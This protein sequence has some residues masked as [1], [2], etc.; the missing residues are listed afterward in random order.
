MPVI[1]WV[2]TNQ[3]KNEEQQG[4]KK[5]THHH[6]EC[7]PFE[8]PAVQIRHEPNGK[9]SNRRRNIALIRKFSPRKM[10]CHP[11]YAGNDDQEQLSQPD[12][13]TSAQV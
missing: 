12:H 6:D 5:N 2:L 9:R 13:I 1:C 3:D 4:R 8:K 7:V 10:V 11:S